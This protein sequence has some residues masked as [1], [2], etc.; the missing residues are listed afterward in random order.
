[1]LGL[2]GRL[3]DTLAGRLRREAEQQLSAARLPQTNSSALG[4]GNRAAALPTTA[5]AG[6]LSPP[7]LTRRPLPG[8]RFTEL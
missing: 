6:P 7:E 5:A 8:K 2:G 3:G 4:S 1:V